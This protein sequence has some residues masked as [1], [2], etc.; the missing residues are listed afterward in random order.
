MTNVSHPLISEIVSAPDRSR[1]KAP[2]RDEDKFVIPEDRA[3]DTK[4][5]DHND[6][7]AEAVQ[8][9]DPSRQAD[10]APPRKDGNEKVRSGGA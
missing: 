10:T 5:S 7:R 1:P 3:V 2:V 4:N 6:L 9:V 8:P